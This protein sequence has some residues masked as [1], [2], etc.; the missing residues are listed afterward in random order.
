MDEKEKFK[1]WTRAMDGGMEHGV[2]K[3]DCSSDLASHQQSL[4]HML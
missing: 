3:D 4:N 1:Q 2:S